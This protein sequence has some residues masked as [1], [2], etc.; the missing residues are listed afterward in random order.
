MDINKI[1]HTCTKHYSTL[2][3]KSVSFADQNGMELYLL[4]IRMYFQCPNNTM[5]MV[6]LIFKYRININNNRY[7]SSTSASVAEH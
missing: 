4:L 7:F 5:S 3:S 6:Y 2:V 1:I